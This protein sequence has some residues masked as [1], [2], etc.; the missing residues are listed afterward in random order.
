MH[1]A[2][3]GAGGAAVAAAL[4]GNASLRAALQSGWL[5]PADAAALSPRALLTSDF[6]SG[7]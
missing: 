4:A 5:A 6:L 3:G 2:R 7:I 1:G